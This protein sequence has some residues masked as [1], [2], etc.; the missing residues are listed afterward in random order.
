[1]NKTLTISTIAAITLL[2]AC[3]KDYVCTCRVQSPADTVNQ[4]AVKPLDSI[5]IVDIRK[6]KKTEAENQ[7]DM[8][9]DYL[10][11][12]FAQYQK[13]AIDCKLED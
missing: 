9:K 10:D 11:R 4:V 2:V 1:M 7:C 5:T 6:A 12:E 13:R 8:T 3:K